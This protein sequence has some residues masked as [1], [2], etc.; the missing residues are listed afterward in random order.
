MQRIMPVAEFAA[1]ALPATGTLAQA[2]PARGM[3]PAT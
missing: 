3:A 2:G 1:A